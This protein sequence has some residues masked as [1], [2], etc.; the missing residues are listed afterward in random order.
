[1]RSGYGTTDVLYSLSS[2][3]PNLQRYPVWLAQSHSPLSLLFLA[4][5]FF[6]RRAGVERRALLLSYLLVGATW[7]CYLAYYS[8]EDWWYLRFLLPAIPVTLILVALTIRETARL[9]SGP[10]GR[11][12]ATV[13]AAVMLTTEVRFTH[14]RDMS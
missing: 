12:A 13:L 6:W 8:F 11:L 4:P 9:G 14:A 3:W 2:V 5:L 7:L 1:L 10:W